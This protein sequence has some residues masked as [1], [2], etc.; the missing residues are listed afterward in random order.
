VGI[1]STGTA[2]VRDGSGRLKAAMARRRRDWREP[3]MGALRPIDQRARFEL[4]R[5]R[6]HGRSLTLVALAV[7]PERE[8]HVVPRRRLTELACHVSGMVR[9]TDIV[10]VHS[11]F[12]LM[13]LL[14]ESPADAAAAF[15]N[16]LRQNLQPGLLEAVSA[17][18]ASFPEEQQ[19]WDTLKAMAIT[20]E[21]RLALETLADYSPP[22]DDGP[23]ATG[24]LVGL[25]DPGGVRS[26]MVSRAD[27]PMSRG[28]S[29]VVPFI[30]VVDLLQIRA[31][32]AAER[33]RRSPRETAVRAVDVSVVLL[34]APVVVPLL[35]V[36][37]AA[38]KLDTPGPFL[39]A[40]TRVGRQGAPIK[41]LKVR[42][43]VENAEELKAELAH[44]NVMPWPDF[45]IPDDP[46]VTP[47]G[48][49]LRRTTL[50][51]LPQLW[52][53]LRG[54]LTLV[55]PRPCS[56]LADKYELW[57]LERLEA[58]PGLFGQWQAEGRGQAAFDDRCR[59]DI[60]QTRS[61][62]FR[63]NLGLVVKTTVALIK[64]PGE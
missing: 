34:S 26:G 53:V 2:G 1:G 8:G 37:A 41:V 31:R 5:A 61:S 55:G 46:R 18:M 64:R 14:P 19:L 27:R 45:K 36:V 9:E 50:D 12:R 49:W 39:I 23:G 42:T 54:E 58:K 11:P 51:E 47:V 30:D 28:G 44:L 48:R 56:V 52:N 17:G 38:V 60:R 62:S 10:G 32:S 13:V 35:C 57:Q 24:G 22:H 25:R 21:R 63:A 16:R 33:A 4:R 59:F 43:M 7:V 6:R 29:N 3:A 20:R 15:V 40:H